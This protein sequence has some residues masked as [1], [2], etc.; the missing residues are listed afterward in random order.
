MDIHESYAEA[1]KAIKLSRVLK[2]DKIIFYDDLGIYKLL[3]DF[4][5]TDS[6]KEFYDS[7][8]GSLIQYDDEHNAE[9]LHTLESLIKNDWNI[10][11]TAEK[12]F[13]HY[14]TVKYRMKRISKILGIDLQD[15]EQK[16]NLALSLKL[17]KM[18]K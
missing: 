14:N 3:E 7:Y 4:S 13:V 1:Q 10:K 9:L 18:D 12:L 11:E 17:L 5:E 6:I 2:K 8:L 16:F 15:P